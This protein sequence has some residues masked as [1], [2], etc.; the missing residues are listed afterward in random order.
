AQWLTCEARIF[1]SSTSGRSSPAPVTAEKRAIARDTSGARSARG[2]RGEGGGVDRA[3]GAGVDGRR[4]G[5]DGRRDRSAFVVH[6]SRGV[7]DQFGVPTAGRGGSAPRS[8]GGLGKRRAAGAARGA[9]GRGTHRP[10]RPG[11]GAPLLPG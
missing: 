7:A 6:L 2:R 1:T 11:H 8:R 4:H 10:A 9:A 5:L 3:A